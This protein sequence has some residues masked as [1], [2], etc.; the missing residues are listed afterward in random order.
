M[1]NL[2]N[3]KVLFVRLGKIGDIIISSFV[4][5]V[6]KKIFPGIEISLFTLESNREVLKYNT[7][8]D[9]L[10]LSKKNLSLYSKIFHLRKNY[11]DLVIDLNDDPS[12]TSKIIRKVIKAN[13]I[14]GFNFSDIQSEGLFQQPPKDKTHIID[15]ISFL[16]NELGIKLSEKEIHPKLYL[17]TTEN[18]E[19]EKQLNDF[20]KKNKIV[21]INLS[22]G[23]EIRYW[24]IDNWIELI[25]RIHFE[26]PE[27]IF[28]PLS[29][30]EDEHLRLKILAKVDK[31]LLIIQNFKS[32]HHFASYIY[33]SDI[34][35]SPDTAAVHI[36]S[37]F[38]KPVAAIYPDYEWNFVSWKPLSEKYVAIKSKSNLINSVSVDE[39]YNSFMG[40]YKQI[41]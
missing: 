40:L 14:V 35:I 6:L 39:V 15:R 20:K 22:A 13:R 5:E 3:K 1:I 7:D 16:L 28:L 9:Y 8:I 19:I 38:N 34:L 32:F 29:T 25:N 10:I 30:L 36:A 21:A 26:I 23:A 41:F 24:N 31:E 27:I 33:N 17:G 12:T 4:F 18:A 37:A 2:S 11:Y